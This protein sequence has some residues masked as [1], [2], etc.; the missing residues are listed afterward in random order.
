MG[1][2][3]LR[4][5]SDLTERDVL[6][7]VKPCRKITL[8]DD[9]GNTLATD[10]YDLALSW[11]GLA[12]HRAYPQFPYH[13]KE[14]IHTSIYND[15]Y[16]QK[17]INYFTQRTL[18]H[19]VDDPLETDYL[20]QMLY[21]WKIKLNNF[22]TVLGQ[23]G[24]LSAT[25][26]DVREV[27]D[28]PAIKA[29]KEKL[30][31][32]EITIDE[33]EV[34]FKTVILNPDN[35]P[36]NTLALLCR[37]DGVKVNQAFQTVLVR[38]NVFDLNNQILPNAIDAA[39]AEGITNLADSYGESKSAG[40]S[41]I[42]NGKALEDSEY[43]HRKLHLTTNVVT[44]IN[45]TQDCGSTTTVPIKLLTSDNAEALLGKYALIKDELVL[46]DFDNIKQFKK[47]DTVNIR[48]IAYCRNPSSGTICGKCYGK[49]KASI[50]F[51]VIMWRSANPGMF[52]S[53][54]LAER[55]G[56][57][58]LSTKHFL[59]NTITIPFTIRD[60]DK[61]IITTDDLGDTIFLH[62]DLCKKGTTLIL[63][64]SFLAELVDLKNLE[65]LEDLNEDRLRTFN[66]VTI[67]YEIEDPMIGG[68]TKTQQTVSTSVSSRSARMSKEL[69]EY[70]VKN[71]WEVEKK[72]LLV[73]LTNYDV[74]NPL[75]ILPY[76]HEDLDQYRKKIEA[77][78]SFTTRNG[79]WIRRPLTPEYIGE[80]L[81]EFWLLINQKFKGINILHPETIL[82]ALMAKDPSNGLY[83]LP[84]GDEPR[85]FIPFTQCIKNRGMGTLC[86]YQEADEVLEDPKSYDIKQRQA[87]HCETF[88]NLSVK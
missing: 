1:N 83:G 46:L 73:D 37:T 25:A 43:L 66:D 42:S 88:L 56:Q 22:I 24:V 8:V 9:H 3:S 14:V 77:F 41:L 35:L 5:F 58:L 4:E 84:V 6:L 19:H 15:H 45:H 63:D 52:S 78:V 55:I 68:V 38:G 32:R 34:E 10:S 72:T 26:D 79:S 17:P 21:V 74:R 20:K 51:N 57:A 18:M 81:N 11:Y 47:G 50:P 54:V 71:N 61:T 30:N 80:T 75:F 40:K 60:S 70:I 65:S 12:I 62:A 87:G 16:L 36:D 2:L 48:S 27:M 86:I 67:S 76:V 23:S 7:W 31:N 85:Y 64:N 29:I 33:A 53:T 82:Y 28:F 39:Y 69:V 49:L 13:I 59:R 44:S